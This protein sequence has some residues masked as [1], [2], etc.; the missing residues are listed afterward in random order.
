MEHLAAL[1]A[2]ILDHGPI[3]HETLAMPGDWVIEPWNAWSS[4][5]IALPAVYWAWR[6]WG[7]YRQ[8]WFM[9][10]CM[11]LL[12][13]NG[14]GSTLFHAFRSSDFFL[15]LDTIPAALVTLLV[16]MY[17]WYKVLPN[18]W[19]ILGI[20][21]L[22]VGLRLLISQ[23]IQPPL[24]INLSYLVG[25]V[26]FLIPLVWLLWRMKFRGSW[27]IA[28][29]ITAFALALLFREMDDWNLNFPPMG[30]HFLWHVCTGFGGFF[31]GAY[32]FALERPA[33]L[34]SS[35]GSQE[36]IQAL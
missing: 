15:I 11:P 26:A 21:I 34:A 29:T 32:L 28:G 4:L 23:L 33:Q 30:T 13:L 36:Q 5:V 7:N 10:I 16:T 18:R 27:Q 1:E 20:A 12:F 24:S 6:L 8:F 22:T 35:T 31:L 14:L 3:Y 19:G 2:T 9:A 25:G 17:L